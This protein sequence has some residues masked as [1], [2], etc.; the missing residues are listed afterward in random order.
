M[1]VISVVKQEVATWNST[2]A[3][4]GPRIYL[5]RRDYRT[6]ARVLEELLSDVADEPRPVDHALTDARLLLARAYFHSARLGP[7]EEAA[8]ALLAENPTDAYAAL[9]LARTLQRRSRDEEA[10]S[11]LKL[12]TALG[13]P[14][15]S[16][17][18]TPVQ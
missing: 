13:A 8:R 2:S 10:D 18:T 9:L 7:A 12:A 3:S 16:W 5:G 4:A 11:A 15:T 17:E 14:G 6:A 1:V